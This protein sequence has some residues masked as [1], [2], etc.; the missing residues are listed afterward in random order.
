VLHCCIYWLYSTEC[1][2]LLCAGSACILSHAT[3]LTST[4]FFVCTTSTRSGWLYFT[5]RTRFSACDYCQ[6]SL[7]MCHYCSD[8]LRCVLILPSLCTHSV[9][10]AMSWELIDRGCGMHA[11]TFKHRRRRQLFNRSFQRSSCAVSWGYWVCTPQYWSLRETCD[12]W[13]L[14]PYWLPHIVQYK[15]SL[16]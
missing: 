10:V 5:V 2:P 6:G 3:A 11:N 4:F 9:Q 14:H 13:I 1:R 8:L 12:R 7:F 16:S 15:H